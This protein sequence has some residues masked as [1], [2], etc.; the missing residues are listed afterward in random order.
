MCVHKYTIHAY[1]QIHICTVYYIVFRKILYLG[2][3]YI[4]T[5]YV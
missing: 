4:P 3:D 5:I 2:R 1:I